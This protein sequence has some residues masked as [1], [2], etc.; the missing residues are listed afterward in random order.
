[1]HY[2]KFIYKRFALA[3]KYLESLGDA[4]SATELQPTFLKAIVRGKAFDEQVFF[5]YITLLLA[6][7]L[8]TE[9]I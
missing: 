5:I 8:G 4:K 9:D 3:G 6:F 7:C 1:M 2:F